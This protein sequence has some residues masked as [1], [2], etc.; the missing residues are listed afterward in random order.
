MNIKRK[1]PL[2]E[3]LADALPIDFEDLNKIVDQIGD[4]VEIDIDVIRPPVPA[5]L[6]GPPENCY[7]AEGGEYEV[8]LEPEQI[9]SMIVKQLVAAMPERLVLPTIIEAAWLAIVES[10]QTW[11]D[12]HLDDLVW[13]NYNDEPEE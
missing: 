9:A 10:E 12:N 5:F 11:Q 1:L 8:D 13:D 4:E 6:G 3:I 7:P 2:G